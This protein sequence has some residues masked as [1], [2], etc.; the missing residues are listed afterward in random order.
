MSLRHRGKPRHGSGRGSSAVR[1]SEPSMGSEGLAWCSWL[2]LMAKVMIGVA[3]L[4]CLVVFVVIPRIHEHLLKIE[5]DQ[6]SIP[7]ELVALPD[8]RRLFFR[9]TLARSMS[10][11]PVILILNGWAADY[12]LLEELEGDLAAAF[13]KVCIYDRAG[14]GYSDPAPPGTL[15]HRAIP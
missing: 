11:E 15:L 2:Y 3:A 7:G 12:R 6:V 13:K 8:G 10:D 4:L 14:I 5:R 9:C 1:K